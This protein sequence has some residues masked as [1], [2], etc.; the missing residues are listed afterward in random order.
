MGRKVNV[1]KG[2]GVRQKDEG[3][4]ITQSTQSDLKDASINLSQ[5]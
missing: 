5:L 3:V 1:P 4:G 2:E